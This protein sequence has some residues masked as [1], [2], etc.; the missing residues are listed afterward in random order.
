MI[1]G[2][3]NLLQIYGDI[4]TSTKC[5]TEYW[6]KNNLTISGFKST[7]LKQKTVFNI[8]TPEDDFAIKLLDRFIRSLYEV[9]QSDRNRSL[10]Y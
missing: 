3:W 2:I 8:M 4:A 1:F 6:E 7:T 9:R 5:I 10:A